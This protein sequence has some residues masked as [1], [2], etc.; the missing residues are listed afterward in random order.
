VGTISNYSVKIFLLKGLV[1]LLLIVAAGIV[2]RTK[3]SELRT[4]YTTK[5]LKKISGILFLFI[6][7]LAL[8]LTYS[9]NPA[10]G[11]QKIL[12]FIIS[13]VP[14][15]LV[16][17]YLISTLTERRIKLFIY[18]LGII[19]VIT[20]SYILIDYP[21]D[22]STIYHYKPGR[23]SHVIYGRMIS[24]FAVVLLLYIMWK[25]GRGELGEA[26]LLPKNLA[27][28]IQVRDTPRQGRRWQIIFLIFITSIAIYGTYLSAFRAGLVG[29]VLVG[30]GLLVI[31]S[32]FLVC[33]AWS[34]SLPAGRQVRSSFLRNLFTGK[35][36]HSALTKNE[37]LSTKE[38]I[39]D[40]GQANPVFGVLS[41][42]LV[43]ITLSALLIFLVPKPDI[44]NYR[45]DNLTAFDD[46]QFK[47]DPAIH[48]RLDAWE[49]SCEM[50][51]EHPLLG[52]GLGAFNGYNNIEW[53]R[54]IKYSHNIILEMTAEGGVVGLL[55]LCS[56]FVVIFKSSYRFSKC[57]PEPALPAGR[58]VSGSAIVVLTF[59]LFSLFLALFSK[60]FSN[61]SLLW[62]G[63]A[64]V[65]NNIKQPK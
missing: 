19:S 6:G 18:S 45:F 34:V 27:T 30:G 33:S 55:V 35:R 57:H 51:K 10:Y 28:D 25:V 43:I 2:I 40:H 5:G 48:S 53:T 22:Q 32:W 9:S 21:F 29:V 3:D 58:L 47:G 42:L 64:F 62:I 17:Y 61:Q 11:F 13:I 38:Q 14:S 63:L 15:I 16:F 31:S 4:Q 59:F 60:E 50:I 44:I 52:T 1:S 26:R 23:W 8:T 46:L 54:V 39:L 7:Y 36:V 12:N 56:L 65:G 41:T 49:L 20:V 24:S 37:A